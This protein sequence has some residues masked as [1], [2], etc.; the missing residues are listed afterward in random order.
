MR[1]R[2]FYLIQTHSVRFIV[3]ILKRGEIKSFTID[4]LVQ[5]IANFDPVIFENRDLVDTMLSYSNADNGYTCFPTQTDV[6]Y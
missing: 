5:K 6:C 2:D 1:S 3:I 4:A